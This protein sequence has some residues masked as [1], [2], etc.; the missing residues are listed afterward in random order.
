[1]SGQ[2]PTLPSGS[3]SGRLARLGE[4]PN[5][6]VRTS[7]PAAALGV[8]AGRRS[9]PAAARDPDWSKTSIDPFILERLD[10]QGLT[11]SPDADR[12]VLI[13]RATF[14]L[15]GL[16]PIPE[17]VEAFVADTSPEAFARVVDRLLASPRY[18]ERWG[19]YWLDV[20]RYAD[21]KGYVFFQD[22]DYPWAS[23]YRDYVI[24]AF[25]DD[26][27]YDRFLVEQIAADL[28]P[29]GADGRPLRALGF[30]TLGGRFMNN[31]HDVIDDQIDVV[32]RGLLGLTVTL[33][34]VPRPQ[35]RPD[36]DAR[37]LLALRR[38]RLV[39]RADSASAIRGPSLDGRLR[40]VRERD[41]PARAEAAGLR[42]GEA[43]RADPAGEGAGRRL[44]VAAQAAQAQPN[45]EDFM[46]LADGTDLNPKM[47]LRWQVYLARTLKR[48]DPVFIPWHVLAS[49]PEADFA[50]R[51]EA[52][53]RRWIQVRDQAQPVNPLIALA[54]AARPPRSLAEAAQIYAITVPRGRSHVCP[55]GSLG[56]PPWRPRRCRSRRSKSSVRS[57]TDPTPPERADEPGGRPGPLA[58]SPLADEV[59]GASH[60][61]REM[62]RHRS[63][64]PARAMALEDAPVPVEPRVFVRGNPNNLGEA[65]PRQFLGVLSGPGR[66]PFGD[67]SG[68][69]ELARAIV[70]PGNPLTAR[71]LVNRVW[72]HHFGTPLV[73]TPSDFG[74][75]SDPPTHPELLD[76]LATTFVRTGGRSSVSIV[77]SCFL[78]PISKR[79]TTAPTA[80]VSTRRTRSYWRMNRR[81]LDFEATR[82]SLLAV[83]GR[84]SQSARRPFGQ[85]RQRRWIDPAHALR[86]HRSTGPSRSLPDV[87]LPRPQRDQPPARQYDRRA[88]GT[89]Y[90]EP[91]LC[92]RRARDV[93]KRPELAREKDTELRIDRLNRLLYGRA[94]TGA[95]DQARQGV[96][97]QRPT[98]GRCSGSATSRR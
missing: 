90:D 80:G 57:F 79:A 72:M 48:R 5:G 91:S 22:K 89:L 38:I 41:E 69:L 44:P 4:G 19:R 26:L 67:G 15:I 27:P 1:M 93:L 30:L 40:R 42:R 20:A 47:L 55:G 45:T 88:A 31:I 9:A 59:E 63:R 50:A 28:L 54:L 98:A 36:P 77:G 52:L 16:P 39:G 46:L 70:D 43:P 49:L 29:K 14:D 71:V 17:E 94:P 53:C 6:G 84:L 68:R 8:P 58:R 10:A 66:R 51:A 11:P 13:R 21:T 97:R 82:D 81:R 74:L 92:P 75:R 78:I 18:G 76:H 60:S 64:R 73:G 37:L 32:T 2:S 25:N 83:S 61:G 35:V 7:I 12:R 24:E 86:V 65:V 34:P 85:S 62:A 56:D 95:G 96:P 87:R 33:R 3:G 23:T